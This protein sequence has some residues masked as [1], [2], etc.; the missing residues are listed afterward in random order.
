MNGI[1]RKVNLDGS[2]TYTDHWMVAMMTLYQKM[3][4]LHPDWEIEIKHIHDGYGIYL[5]EGKKVVCDAI[6]HS[7]S[8]GH[9]ENLFEFWTQ[10]R[11]ENPVGWLTAEEVISCFE[12]TVYA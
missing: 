9:E 8:Y 10:K 6:L 1:T 2:V 12:H 11:K 3:L 4:D 5:L 7:G